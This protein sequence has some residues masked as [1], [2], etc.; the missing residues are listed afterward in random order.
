[1]KLLSATLR[2]RF[3]NRP[4]SEHE[5]ALVRL[6][7]AALIL[8]YLL[9][10]ASTS[11][12]LDSAFFWV[13]GV[14][15]A[16]AVLGFGLLVA[17][18][19]SPAVSRLRRLIGMAADFST[20]AV[21]MSL[22]GEALAP[23]YIVYLWVAIGNGL[24]FG[25]RYL[26]AAVA[27]A[28]VSFGYVILETPYWLLNQPLAWGLLVGLI[29]IPAYLSSLLKALTQATH[30][31][32]RANEAKSRFLANMSHEFRTPLNGIVGMSELLVTTPLDSEQRECAQVI[33]ASAQSLLAL[34]EDV[35]DISAIEAGKL[36]CNNADFVL[37]D[38][39]HG[40]HVMLQPIAAKKGL[41]FD[42]DVADNVP[43]ALHG[44]ANHLRQ[45]LLNLIFNA[46]KFTESGGVTVSVSRV[47]ALQDSPAWLRFSVCDTGI[48]IATEAQA[49]IFEAFEQ[50]ETGH[51]RRFGG[52]GLGTTIAKG[53]V[54]SMGGRI[55]FESKV[56][57]GS[58]FWIEVP[59]GSASAMAGVLPE[60]A[61]VAGNIIHFDDP[62]VRHRIRVRSLHLLV[63]D[64][65]PANL[66]MLRRLLEKAGHQTQIVDNGEDALTALEDTTFDAVIIDLHM[67]GISGLDVLKQARFMA[68]GHSL[69]PFLVFSADA[70]AQTRRMVEEA[71][72][73][74]FLTKPVV[75]ARLLDALSDIALASDTNAGVANHAPPANAS[76]GVISSSVIKDLSILGL[77]DSFI[78]LFVEECLRDALKCIGDIEQSGA[79]GD[80]D[81]V[82]DRCHALKGVAGNMG[83]IQLTDTVSNLM[84]SANGQHAA[85]WPA[86]IQRLREQL[87][88]AR[89][90]LHGYTQANSI[91]RNPDAV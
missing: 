20:L 89:S 1:M 74:G 25:P 3:N 10:L 79:A 88:A 47:G 21:V 37:V 29:A 76:D 66:T 51:A 63:A 81:T 32:R 30:E 84:S 68:A 28:A 39:L 14:I 49:R 48:G 19:L 36:K 5:Q 56:D 15:V 72:A 58:T 65:Q 4:D 9:G 91:K 86:Q 13:L 8:C 77:G 45:I 82:R 62:F 70:T 53:L 38:T 35:L 33:Q 57:E 27:M 41:T 43:V 17:I 31:A 24:R 59:F 52:T 54:E 87:E 6:V 34:V 69:T 61:P 40:V 78:D 80:W 73:F 22:H 23:L 85:N 7:I 67:P 83:A 2:S 12:Y 55:G 44:D 26:A 90:I 60:L 46:V 71:G 64:D 42:L 75:V 16:E 50:A 18:A 11:D